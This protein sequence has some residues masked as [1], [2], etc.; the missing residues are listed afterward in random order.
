MDA[1]KGGGRS[2]IA[3]AALAIAG[4]AVVLAA[5]PAVSDDRVSYPL[6]THSFQ[7]GQ[8]FFALTQALM[9]WG[10]LALVGS[11]IAG[12]G[13]AARVWS[14][15][16]VAGMLLTVLG[17][18]ALI[19]VAGSDADAAATSAATT[20]FGLG[21]LLADVGLI[22][23]G[24]LALRLRQWWLGWAA[25]PLVLGL[26]QVLIVTPVSFAFGFASTES[27]L[28]IA[29]ADLLVALIGLGLLRNPVA[30]ES[31]RFPHPQSA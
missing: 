11:E 3:G 20:V 14:K 26:F 31:R 18:L 9:A 29:V 2:A 17:E 22:G 15:L 21:V 28:V 13:R 23:F 7:L 1:I 24:V 12:S 30:E 27:F 10:I 25:L 5:D 19:P 16:A 6:S 4:N 8:V